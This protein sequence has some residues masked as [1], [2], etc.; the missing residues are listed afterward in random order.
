MSQVICKGNW[1]LFKGSD[2]EIEKFKS[3]LTFRDSSAVYTKLYRR[4][5]WNGVVKLYKETMKGL[6]FRSGL[7]GYLKENFPDIEVI[8]VERK[9]EV[10]EGFVLPVKL[11]EYQFNALKAVKEKVKGIISI[12]TSG[13][14]TWIAVGIFKMFKGQ[15]YLYLVHRVELLWQVSALLEEVFPG[16]VGRVGG[17]LGE[18]DFSKKYVVGM[19]Q[20]LY[21]WV[22]QKR[23]LEEFKK[24]DVL[25]VDECHHIIGK[26][27]REVIDA[28]EN[29]VV[30][31]GLTGT[32]PNDLLDALRVKGV[33]GDVIYE[34]PVEELVKGG[35]VVGPYVYM[36]KGDW[37]NQEEF[38]RLKSKINWT[39]FDFT[40]E[41]WEAVKEMFIVRNEKRNR[42]IVDLIKG[43]KGV[44]VIVDM[45]EHGKR[46]SEMSG[47]KFVWADSEDRFEVFKKFK[48]GEIDC[49]I[50]SPILEEGVDVSGIE[51]VVLA[52]GGKSKRKL[53]QRIGRGM[54]LAEGKTKVEIIDFYDEAPPL[55]KKHT[56]ERMSVYKKMGFPVDVKE[57]RN[58]S[59]GKSKV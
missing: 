13:G 9:L 51:V 21:S 58:E 47:C 56:K 43:R 36:Y 26:T 20:K 45:I 11:R 24:I 10:N 25:V 18:D 12:P 29:V 8:D 35:Y 16:E 44:L 59:L 48:K 57:V 31:I 15:K 17:N 39:K 38:E 49:L 55:L 40:R 7:I 22:R 27:Y 32:V 53:L 14:K 5:I 50:S 23:E 1:A 34:V 41:Y 52:S 4:G 37:F 19:V 30:K 46:L 42:L 2:A 28:C 6:M 54:R 33:L 3:L